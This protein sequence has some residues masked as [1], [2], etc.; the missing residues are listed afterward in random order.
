MGKMDLNQGGD[1]DDVFLAMHKIQKDESVTGKPNV[2]T[3]KPKPKKRVV[4]F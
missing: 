3:V 1:D 4:S 2:K